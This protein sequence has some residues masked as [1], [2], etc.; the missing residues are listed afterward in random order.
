M[1]LFLSNKTIKWSNDIGLKASLIIMQQFNVQYCSFFFIII[2]YVNVDVKYMA[3]LGW[4]ESQDVLDFFHEPP[5]CSFVEP[6][7]KMFNNK[8][9]L[10][11]KKGSFFF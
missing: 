10:C 9:M 2:F 5:G 7:P 3:L 11:T 4:C 6:W 8:E 1:Y